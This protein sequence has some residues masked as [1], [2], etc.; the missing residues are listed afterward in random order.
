[1]SAGNEC[2]KPSSRTASLVMVPDIAATS[3]FSGYGDAAPMVV[4]GWPAGSEVALATEA[5]E[6]AD[7]SAVPLAVVNETRCSV[8]LGLARVTVKPKVAMPALPSA[9]VTSLIEKLGAD[10]VGVRKL[11]TT[12]LL[13][14][15]TADASTPMPRAAKPAQMSAMSA[16]VPPPALAAARI[17]SRPCSSVGFDGIELHA[18]G[19]ELQHALVADREASRVMK[20]A[21]T[22][23]SALAHT[24]PMLCTAKALLEPIGPARERAVGEVDLRR[25]DVGEGQRVVRLAVGAEVRHHARTG[26]GGCRSSSCR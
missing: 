10:P 3:R 12:V 19:D 2:E 24:S 4:T 17:E 9:A 15:L 5:V 14:E 23:K 8:M 7:A 16:A 20:R 6:G 22:S 1:M 21:R 18:V 25:V 26:S 11:S 13:L